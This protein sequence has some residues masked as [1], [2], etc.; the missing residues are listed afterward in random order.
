L[1]IDTSMQHRFVV[2][3]IVLLACV[4]STMAPRA[5]ADDAIF[6]IREIPNQG[7]SVAAELADFDG[8]QRKDL[9]VVSIEGIPPEESRTIRVYLQ[10]ADGSLP[11]TPDHSISLPRWSTFYDVA[12]LKNTPG[13]E[14]VLLRPDGVTILSLADS[15]GRQWDLP[16]SGP[17]T[18]GVSDDERGFDRIRLVY[19]GIAPEPVIL[20]PQIGAMSILTTTGATL[21]QI[22]V[23]RRGNYFVVPRSG[24]IAVESDIQLFLDS[25]KVS[26]GDVDGDGRADIVTS[27]RHELRVFLQS[28][29]GSYA[30]EANTIQA[31][32]FVT[33]RDHIRGTGGVVT[34]TGDIDGDGRLDL[35]ITHVEGSFSDATTSTYIF[36][37]RD[38]GWNLDEPDDSFI[39]EGALGSDLLVDIDQDNQLELV[40]LQLKFSLFEIIELFLSR[41]V[42]SQ[43]TIHRLES[44]GHY[45]AKPWVKRKIST[46]IS[47][48]T[49]RSKGFI[50]PVGIDLN[51]DGYADI[52]S[53]AN[54]KGM[55]V[56]LGGG[57]KPFARRSAVQKFKTAGVIHFTD[58]DDDGLP[59]FVLFDPQKFDA[60]IQIGL[61]LGNLPIFPRQDSP[62]R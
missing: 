39:N 19:S 31:L 53:S 45:S 20:V 34:I 12:D 52:L 51:A 11:S 41:E 62:G 58:F 40:R 6:D 1:I 21:A 27:T 49:F 37:N 24:P 55:E 36:R 2:G 56:F 47:F 22:D 25:P 3:T 42:D 61:N 57:K 59:D 38:G 32:R 7:R 18:V 8:D 10:Q 26:V 4:G 14:L 23:A 35:L 46:G 43:L 13:D 15:S 29:S 50:P 5:F 33:Q 60:A 28:E 54:G 48:D 9:M 44:D 30:R 17:S 16:T